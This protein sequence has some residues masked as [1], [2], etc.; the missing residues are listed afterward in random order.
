MKNVGFIG[1]RGMVGS[2]L[3]QRMVEEGDFNVI[4]PVFFTTSQQGEEAPVFG[5]HR[6]T[7]QDAFDID[8]LSALDIIISCQGGDYTNE[9]YPKLRGAGWKGFWIDAASALRMKDD[10]IIILDPVNHQHIQDGLNKGIK[11]FVGGNCTVSLML[12]SLGGLFANDLVEWASVATYQAASGAGA[13]NMRELLS[14]MGSL[15][16]QVAKELQNPASA[17]LEIEKKVTDFTRS[18]SMPTDAFGVP[19]AGSLIPWID[20]ALENGQSREEWKGQAETNKILATGSNIIP[21]DGLCVRVGALRCHSQAFTLKL[22]KD[23]PLN[24][25]E[26]LLASHNEWVKVV[27]NDREITMRELTP[28]AVTGTLNT[29][30]GRLRKLNMGPEY[31]SAFTVGDQ[32][33]WG[34]AEPLRRMLRILL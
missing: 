27:P 3:M 11:T 23:I 13:R 20:K 18:G 24:D 32:L 16:A 17:I 1:W 29:P 25:V 4:H 9:V 30:V 6:S 14:Q 33:L 34:A 28:A 5:G 7:L 8:A 10:A 2:V 19:L 22:K 15:H 12:M 26:Q 21:V 31:L